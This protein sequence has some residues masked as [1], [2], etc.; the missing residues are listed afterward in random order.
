VASHPDGICRNNHGD[1]DASDY[2]CDNG[3][4]P[5]YIHGSNNEQPNYNHDICA[6]HGSDDQS[7]NDN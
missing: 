2:S 1:N 7:S 6:H 3:A 4:Q 5:N